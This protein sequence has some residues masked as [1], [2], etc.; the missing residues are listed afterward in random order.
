MIAFSFSS[1]C[2]P[3]SQRLPSLRVDPKL[4]R[5]QGQPAA[6][7]TFLRSSANA[8][9]AYGQYRMRS[10]TAHAFSINETL[11]TGNMTDCLTRT[12]VAWWSTV[13][14]HWGSPFPGLQPVQSIPALTPGG[15]KWISRHDNPRAKLC[16]SA[17]HRATPI[18]SNDSAILCKHEHAPQHLLRPAQRLSTSA[19]Y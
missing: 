16:Q 14:H 8:N 11:R 2:E 18:N 9:V 10:G 17:R 5:C 1:S 13:N 6:A 7:E 4:S 3:S 19:R 12:L 15:V